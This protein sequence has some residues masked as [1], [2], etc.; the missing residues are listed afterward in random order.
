MKKLLTCL[1]LA[2]ALSVLCAFALAESMVSWGGG[3]YPEYI[4]YGDSATFKADPIEG[5]TEYRIEVRDFVDNTLMYSKT[6]TSAGATWP[7]P[8]SA[9]GDKPEYC[10]RLYATVN[11]KV[12]HVNDFIIVQLDRE[13]QASDGVIQVLSTTTPTTGD[14]AVY[15]HAVGAK[16]IRIF[17]GEAE[18]YHWTAE[19]AVWHG[20][21]SK[22]GDY[23][24]YCVAIYEDGH[25]AE[26]AHQTVTVTS[27]GDMG[28]PLPA[29]PEKLASGKA[30]T[31]ELLPP[32]IES[33]LGADDDFFE[34]V[35]IYDMATGEDVYTAEYSRI[36]RDSDWPALG[37]GKTVTVPAST[38]TAG[39]SYEIEFHASCDGW[40]AYD[41]HR[42]FVVTGGTQ[43]N[44]T[45]SIDG[46]SSGAVEKPVHDTVTV[47]VSAPGA[48]ALR[49]WNNDYWQ[50]SWDWNNELSFDRD[51][52]EA[53]YLL[54]TWEDRE[55]TVFA[56]AYYGEVDDDADLESLD[57]GTK[58]SNVMTISWY[59]EEV[60]TKPSF[61]GLPDVVTQGEILTFTL[62][63]LPEN[64]R[65][66]ATYVTDADMEYVTDDWWD[67]DEGTITVYTACMEP[68]YY[69]M[70]VYVDAV[71]LHR[72][73][74][75]QLFK[76]VAPSSTP[77]SGVW[78]TTKKT[79]VLTYEEFQVDVY[80]PGASY[81]RFYDQEAW[82]Y[83][84]WWTD[85][86]R[87]KL[88]FRFD[89]DQE[90]PNDL[91]FVAVYL[92][93]EGNI[94]EEKVSDVLRVTAYSR[95]EAP[96]RLVADTK[97]KYGNDY[98]F[99]VEWLELAEYHRAW[100]VDPENDWETIW[101]TDEVC[102]YV[103]EGCTYTV[104]AD[105][106]EPDHNYLLYVDAWNITGY[107]S[108]SKE[109]NFRITQSKVDSSLLLQAW[110]DDGSEQTL[111][112]GVIEVPAG[113]CVGY[114]LD[115]PGATA[116][117]FYDNGWFNVDVEDGHASHYSNTD[118]N[119]TKMVMARATTDPIDEDTDWDSVSWGGISNT[120]TVKSVTNGKTN[121]PSISVEDDTVAKGSL[122]PVTLTGGEALASCWMS[123]RSEDGEEEYANQWY[124][125]QGTNNTLYIDTGN[126][127]VGGTYVVCLDGYALGKRHG[128]GPQETFTVTESTNQSSTGVTMD[129]SKTDVIAGEEI[130]VSV[131]VTDPECVIA[132]QDGDER[133]FEESN[134]YS[135]M[136]TWSSWDAGEHDLHVDAFYDS[137]L[138]TSNHVTVTVH[139]VEGRIPTVTAP[140]TVA[141][142]DTLPVTVDFSAP[143]RTVDV[144]LKVTNSSGETV[145]EKT[146]SSSLRPATYN[147]PTASFMTGSY[148]VQATVYDEDNEYRAESPASFRVVKP[149]AGEV[150]LAVD[151]PS[152]PRGEEI[153]VSFGS[154]GS[155]QLRLTMENAEGDV[156]RQD[157]Y[158]GPY[159]SDTFELWDVQKVY[160]TAE[161]KLNG[162]WSAVSDTV[163]VQVTIHGTLGVPT[164]TWPAILMKG[165]ALT[166]SFNKLKNAGWYSVNIC[167]D[168]E[169]YIWYDVSEPGERTYSP[170]DCDGL[171][172]DAGHTYQ[173]GIVAWQRGY[174]NTW[175]AD[176][177]FAVV[178]PSRIL[179][180][181][182]GLT[183]IESEAFA[184]VS[185]QMIVVP[186]GV[187]KIEARA[188]A[189]CP[190]LVAVVIPSSVKG[191]SSR[192]FEGCRDNLVRVTEY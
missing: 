25:R 28:L 14:F 132:F 27:N 123:I 41:L 53:D 151:K 92:D 77:E 139:D 109:T 171:T 140:E 180:L 62:D 79:R 112:T 32:A 71:G 13:P 182:A 159:A 174:D 149:T 155:T 145:F 98:S 63:G 73:E 135:W 147:V 138:I 19:H 120:I 34:S 96:L 121:M 110:A 95:G 43:S 90:G 45:V 85:N 177:G 87:V 83:D 101:D 169:N 188:F 16:L 131:W 173:G 3:T 58:Y 153:T 113:T 51:T 152:V 168:G 24:V 129:V 192:A 70:I 10:V 136:T 46:V 48:T 158:D 179:T 148:A 33:Q 183:T 141:R 44:V 119:A 61:S 108:W 185:A 106:F 178:D 12:K 42:Y 114:E 52:G 35:Y 189:D 184:N 99:G 59:G 128:H 154:T 176:N 72:V 81:F 150:V 105:T 36:G 38:F 66:V 157:T 133:Y 74:M 170:S 146:Y 37:A 172:L 26:S 50:Y 21:L 54:N 30:L 165:D 65:D 15:G 67:A 20:A 190:N 40:D 76:V 161:A 100:I 75:H 143:G 118:P 164:Q 125:A 17:V 102:N 144:G 6:Y 4:M 7:I 163:P 1:L 56:Q 49:V 94:T 64:T 175:N 69:N 88:D 57:W 31:L 126:L 107:D 68:G 78:V 5:A 89:D 97:V 115:C 166:F 47:H 122:L 82:W 137:G 39:G 167:R 116:A 93:D 104:P 91:Q 55:T 11:G 142:G 187:T 134:T 160:F 127:D 111:R 124:G 86:G 117:Q 186:S 162:A 80:A 130:Y 29:I 23:E 18:Y 156:L 181:P 191:V 60:Q 8:A 103:P 9:F 2:V 84:E 22:P